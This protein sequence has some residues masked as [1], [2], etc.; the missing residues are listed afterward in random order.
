MSTEADFRLP[1]TVI[2]RHYRVELEPD[3]EAFT[4]EGSE[5]VDVDVREPTD[6]VVLNA[7][8]LD[9]HSAEMVHPAS[10]RRLPASVSYDVGRER[11]ILEL[12]E[13][14]EMGSWQLRTAFRGILNDELV[15]FYRTKYTDATG[16][17]K[18]IATSQ[19]E[20][21]HA[22]RAL[23]CWDEPDLKATFGITL[24][25]PE[26]LTAISNQ[27]ERSRVSREEGR[28]AVTFEDTMVMSTYLLAFVVGELE[29][30]EPVAVDGIP[31]RIVHVPGKGHLTTFATE[32]AVHGLQYLADYYGIPYPG[33][34]LDMIAVPD[35]AWGAME[36]LGAII[37]RESDLLVDPG[38]A[39]QAEIERVAGVV[40]HELAHMWF[41]DLVTMRWWDGVWLNEAFATFMEVKCT[42]HFR[43][44]WHSWLYFGGDR[45]AA[46]EIDALST[47]RPVEFPVAA[48]HE[49]DAMFDLLTYEKGSSVL[50]MLEQYLGE[51]VFREGI[52]A[53]L[54]KHA[55]ANTVTDDLWDALEAAS[56]EPVGT[57]MH[58]W[59]Y[60]GGL[61]DIHVTR[62]G[63]RYLLQQYQFRYLGDAD[64]RWKVPL[65]YRSG[66]ED[67]RLLLDEVAEVAD[68]GPIVVNAG[69]HGFYRVRYNHEL[70]EE[71][72][73]RIQELPAADRYVTG[74]GCLGRHPQRRDRGGRLRRP[75]GRND[76]RARAHRLECD[77]ACAQ[78]AAPRCGLGRPARLCRLR[79]RSRCAHGI[80]PRVG[81]GTR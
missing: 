37:Y 39:T 17:E 21:T 62:A 35:F 6:R 74:E 1:R 47:T 8:E 34:K 42:D 61:P 45:N 30:T 12:A 70:L 66:G 4:F 81:T 52:R 7:L 68:G 80:D 43:P 75:R 15:G 5:V 11:A 25:A 18:V 57:I 79:A 63:G 58:Q 73:D 24:V 56:G 38:S 49:A 72:I 26:H 46:M 27:P 53:Y 2:P 28:V 20:S 41:G 40:N 54:R 9:I 77:A 65:L 76:P 19:F 48:P 31:V 67:R 16:T 69:G 14:A 50:R 64:G 59:I 29:A 32:A 51:N 78:R 36:N 10:G 71:A 55:Y 60:Q 13:P 44:E 23:P 22:R 33:D 3:L